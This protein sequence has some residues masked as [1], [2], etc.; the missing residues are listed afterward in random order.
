VT[1]ALLNVKLVKNPISIILSGGCEDNKLIVLSHFLQKH[2][3][4]R[5]DEEPPNIILLRRAH[6][7]FY[8]VDEG[9]I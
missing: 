1:D 4:S 6:S 8:I 7:N 5:P 9:F 3:S 2:L